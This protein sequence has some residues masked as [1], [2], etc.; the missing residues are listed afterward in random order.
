MTTFHVTS[1]LILGISLFILLSLEFRD[2][3]ECV[4]HA[5]FKTPEIIT[6]FL[7]G[8]HGFSKTYLCCFSLKDQIFMLQKLL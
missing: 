4:T 7:L 5:F 3:T 6:R 1:F 8:L 2:Q